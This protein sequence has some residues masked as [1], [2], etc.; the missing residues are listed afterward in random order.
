MRCLNCHNDKLKPGEAVCP[1]CGVE[2]ESMLS[3]CLRPGTLLNNKRY[4]IDYPLG[5]GGFGITYRAIHRELERAFAIKEFYPK[6][7]VTRGTTGRL[8][9]RG[10]QGEKYQRA[11]EKF[12]KEAQSLALI[13]HPNVSFANDVFMEETLGTAYL[14]MNLV[15]GHTLRQ[16]LKEAKNQGLPE[17]RV[18]KIM[19]ELVSALAAAHKKNVS[20]LDIKPENI[21]INEVDGRTVLVDFGAARVD[22][23]VETIDPTTQPYT[24][25]YAPPEV[26]LRGQGKSKEKLGPYSDIFELGMLLHELRT[27][28]PPLSAL[29]RIYPSRIE[30]LDC[31]ALGE[32]WAQMI[33]DATRFTIADRPQD[34]AVW[35]NYEAHIRERHTQQL[36]DEEQR[37]HRSQIEHIEINRRQA[38]SEKLHMISILEQRE[39]THATLQQELVS[40]RDELLGEID[41]LNESLSLTEQEA[42]AARQELAHLENSLPELLTA[43]VSLI[44]NRIR[45][46]INR[47]Y[48][49]AE[50]FHRSYQYTKDEQ[51]NSAYN[52]VTVSVGGND[53][54]LSKAAL[55]RCFEICL[56]SF[57]ISLILAVFFSLSFVLVSLGAFIVGAW[58]AYKIFS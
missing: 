50:R 8:A 56:W 7:L 26:I 48:T 39:Q 44:V 29:D 3:G 6:D 21:M 25:A 20:H 52:T 57:P 9:L 40:E 34:V 36:R 51:I 35:W 17:D 11:L 12:Y 53:I 19:K 49:F 27:G 55:F 22:L 33:T 13:D 28:A 58:A 30:A 23:G 1:E 2:V 47:A 43:L 46:G 14:V 24:Y 37:R 32:P 18:R 5:K 41:Q 42:E 4:Q 15:T 45:E 31:H 10:G 16:E 54:V 38:E